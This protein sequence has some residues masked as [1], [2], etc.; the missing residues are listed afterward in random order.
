MRVA[1]L[2]E[3]GFKE[4]EVAFPSASDTEFGFVRGLIEKKMG[5]KE[6]VWLQVSIALGLSVSR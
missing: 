2:V 1:Q 5:E 4:I 6:S 3:I